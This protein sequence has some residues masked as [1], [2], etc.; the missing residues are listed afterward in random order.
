MNKFNRSRCKEH[1]DRR[2]SQS[3]LHEHGI[4]IDYA[5]II[6]RIKNFAWENLRKYIKDIR[7]LEKNDV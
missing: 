6:N 3:H 1:P 2:L 7:V 5:I 4:E